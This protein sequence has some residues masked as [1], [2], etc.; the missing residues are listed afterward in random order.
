MRTMRT[1]T[2][3]EAAKRMGKAILDAQEAPLSL[4]L[5]GRPVAVLMSLAEWADLFD[6]R[7]ALDHFKSDWRAE[8]RA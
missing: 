2:T 1:I 5:R 4:S 8:K 3:T 7:A 6:A